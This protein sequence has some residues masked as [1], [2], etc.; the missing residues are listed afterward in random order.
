MLGTRRSYRIDDSE[1]IREMN[2]GNGIFISTGINGY[3]EVLVHEKSPRL[4]SSVI[5][6]NFVCKGGLIYVGGYPNDGLDHIDLPFG[7]DF[8]M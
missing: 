4:K 8:F 1:L 3:Y 2:R 6:M 7:G 5:S